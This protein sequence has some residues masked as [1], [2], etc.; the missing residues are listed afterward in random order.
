MLTT[1]DTWANEE[2]TLEYYLPN[3]ILLVGASKGPVM[4][5]LTRDVA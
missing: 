1:C 5:S 4:S 2:G 3:R